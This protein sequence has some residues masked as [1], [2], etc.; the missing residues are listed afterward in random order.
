[1]IMISHDLSLIAETATEVAIMYAGNVSEYADSTTIFK[2]P[3]HP[4]TEK[5]VGAFPSILGSKKELST[6]PG[7]PP[8][9]ISPPPGC[10]FH[11]RCPYAME[12]CK[13]DRPPLRKVGNKNHLVACHL[14]S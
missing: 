10:R 3:L 4:Y 8:D 9:L 6:I 2:E 1:M 11:P 13:K 5:L 7:F 14:V 12:I